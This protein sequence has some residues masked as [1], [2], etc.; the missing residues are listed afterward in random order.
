MIYDL[1]TAFDAQGESHYCVGDGRTTFA[2]T[3]ETARFATAPAAAA[4]IMDIMT[5]AWPTI[6]RAM[7]PVADAQWHQV[8]DRALRSVAFRMFPTVASADPAAVPVLMPEGWSTGAH[9]AANAH[10]LAEGLMIRGLQTA[11]AVSY[12][13]D[14]GACLAAI[15]AVF[16]SLVRDAVAM[17]WRAFLGANATEAPL[18]AVSALSFEVAG[19]AAPHGAGALTAR[20][21]IGEGASATHH[22]LPAFPSNGQ[23]VFF[24]QIA[25]VAYVP[26]LIAKPGAPILLRVIF[27]DGSGKKLSLHGVAWLPDMTRQ[28][29][30]HISVP[31]FETAGTSLIVGQFL[32][33]VRAADDA[34]RAAETAARAAWT[35]DKATQF[36]H[37]LGHR[38]GARLAA[39]FPKSAIAKT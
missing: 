21:V 16:G 13:N 25:D 23:A 9:L 3:S 17:G 4:A 7:Q 1:V 20:I 34:S 33:D 8:L 6:A 14:R 19:D 11:I 2:V 12:D 35:S 5:A 22:V 15:V 37:T 39:D 31:L 27:R 24:H 28:T 26:R 10:G 38:I 32:I 29:Y 30:R 18:H 36:A